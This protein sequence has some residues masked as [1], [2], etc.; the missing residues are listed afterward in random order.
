MGRGDAH[1]GVYL[2]DIQ[3]C[4]SAH[5]DKATHTKAGPI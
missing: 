1:S 2:L 5:T 4:V 3:A